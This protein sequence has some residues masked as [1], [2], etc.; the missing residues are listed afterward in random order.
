MAP[1]FLRLP[2]PAPEDRTPNRLVMVP[3]LSSAAPS[4][5]EM[6]LA[7]DTPVLICTAEFDPTAVAAPANSEFPSPPLLAT[8]SR[9]L[10]TRVPPE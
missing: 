2:P 9:P 1:L 7:S 8:T 3:R 4:L 10:S 5:K 6:L